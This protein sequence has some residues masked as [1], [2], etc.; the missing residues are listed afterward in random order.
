MLAESKYPALVLN[1][2]Y[3]P[4]SY[5][6]LSTI[7]WQEAL[8]AVISDRV[9]SVAEYDFTVRSPSI[10][11]RL[12]SVI[13]LREYQP[14][15]RTPALTRF[16]IWLRDKARCCYCLIL[17]T[18]S[19][20]TFDHILPKSKGGVTSWTNIATCCTTCNLAKGNKLLA[21]CGLKL[22]QKPY[23][24]TQADLNSSGI[25]LGKKQKTFHNTWIDFMYWDSELL[26]D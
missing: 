3:R 5:F 16:N 4:L 8:R 18:E 6:P 11:M 19:E 25:G 12:P 17:L 23:V 7:P 14:L 13:A 9:D 21:N 10:E 2:D 24:P 22:Q 20:F 26:S 1:A 15:T